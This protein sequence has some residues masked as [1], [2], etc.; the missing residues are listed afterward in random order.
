MYAT[1]D[2]TPHRPHPPAGP[3]QRLPPAWKRPTPRLHQRPMAPFLL[4]IQRKFHLGYAWASRL[5]DDDP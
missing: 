1:V 3:E 5:T 4:P 2:R